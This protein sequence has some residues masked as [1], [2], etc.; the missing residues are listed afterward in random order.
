MEVVELSKVLR[1]VDTVTSFCAEKA[2]MW[3]LISELIFKFINMFRLY[4]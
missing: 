2:E 4:Y 3:T 1:H